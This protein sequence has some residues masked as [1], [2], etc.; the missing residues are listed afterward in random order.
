MLQL[1]RDRR[2]P[3]REK[4][5]PLQT[6]S[7]EQHLPFTQSSGCGRPAIVC[8]VLMSAVL[9]FMQKSVMV[10]C[11]QW[12]FHLNSKPFRRLF[13][14]IS[15]GSHPFSRQQLITFQ[16]SF[17]ERLS[18]YWNTLIVWTKIL[19]SGCSLFHE[20]LSPLAPP[21]FTFLCFIISIFYR[22]SFIP[23]QM[24][25]GGICWP[26]KLQ[27]GVSHNC[28]SICKSWLKQHGPDCTRR[29]ERKHLNLNV[30]SFLF[31]SLNYLLFMSVSL[32]LKTGFPI[33][34]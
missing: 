19:Q 9:G 29:I 31:A 14:I 23:L 27:P 3:S 18:P 5:I 11:F 32:S 21:V 24:L 33:S 2:K 6:R 10:F 13:C 17:C 22:I 4:K 34:V 25:C 1:Q 16:I 12:H 8:A 7:P 30:F 15:V 28:K 20:T 26:S